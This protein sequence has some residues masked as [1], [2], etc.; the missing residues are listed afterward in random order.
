MRVGKR[1]HL[2]EAEAEPRPSPSSPGGP[3]AG[4]P[5]PELRW[6]LTQANGTIG[7]VLHQVETHAA[8]LDDDA[9]EQL[10]S[11]VRVVAEELG[12]LTALL[13]APADWDA[14][15]E[16]LLAGEIP[17]FEDNAEDNENE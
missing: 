14:E 9:R 4:I 11:D 8:D 16:R 2:A 12:T 15:Y 13:F 6:L 5:L 10:R 17:P 7:N 3:E 1:R